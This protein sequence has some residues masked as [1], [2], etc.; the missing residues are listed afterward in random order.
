[1]I[2]QPQLVLCRGDG[3]PSMLVVGDTY[4]DDG[5][6]YDMVAWARPYAPGGDAGEA[7]FTSLWITTTSWNADVHLFITPYI[8][9]VALETQ[10][11]FILAA[12]NPQ[13]VQQVH[14]LA[15]SVPYIRDAVE[16]MRVAP[17]GTWIAVRV[18]TDIAGGFGT[19]ER[20]IVDGITCEVEVV[21]ETREATT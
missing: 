4:E 9:G 7:I 20:Q 16:R 17:R 14:E 19:S 10:D 21:T 13:G 18:E 11:I 15:L 1:M 12:A 6:A 5:E 8:D 2:Q 3:T